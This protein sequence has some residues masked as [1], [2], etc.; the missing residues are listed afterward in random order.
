MH[1]RLAAL[2][3]EVRAQR[4]GIALG[5]LAL[6]I[7]LGGP[8]AADQAASRAA[9]LI[10]GKQIADRSL[11][12]KD[13]APSAVSALQGRTGAQ[14]PAGAPGAQGPA[15]PPGAQ[16]PAGPAG[17]D[18]SPQQT[19]ARLTSADGEGSALDADLLDGRSSEYFAAAGSALLDG[20]AAGGDLTGTFPSP[21]LAAG[22]VGG[23]ELAA[24]AVGASDLAPDSVTGAKIATGT[25][26]DTD[27]GAGSVGA[28]EIAPGAIGRSK[29]R[30]GGSSTTLTFNYPAVAASTCVDIPFNTNQAD[31]GEIMLPVVDGS[32]VAGLYLV[33]TVVQQ[34]SVAWLQVCNGS[35]SLVGA[36]SFN[37]TID[38]LGG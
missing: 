6:F 30:S 36:G 28:S 7:A 19:V 32:L 34:Q 9:K 21:Q 33:P 22:S 37:F 24:D 16:G 20:D 35:G 15:G 14:G 2:R 5:T 17:A 3:A 11:T 4:L 26:D 8:A 29:L 38:F 1:F 31:P 18:F 27:L 23:A 13:L 10:T 25:I 12:L